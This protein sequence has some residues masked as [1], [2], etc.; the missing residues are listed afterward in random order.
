M[1]PRPRLTALSDLPVGRDGTVVCV[2]LPEETR[3]RFLEMGLREGTQVRMVRSAPLG[4]AFEVELL[5]YRLAVRRSEA[6]GILV[7]PGGKGKG[8]SR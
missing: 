7:R 8:K 4:G 3:L 6:R 2:D 5:D 1:P